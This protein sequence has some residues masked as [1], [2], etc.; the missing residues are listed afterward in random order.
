MSQK[1]THY[2]LAKYQGTPAGVA[3]LRLTKGIG[4]LQGSAVIPKFRK[5]GI[6]QALVGHRLKLLSQ[7]KI[8]YATAECL[9]DSSAPLCKDLGFETVCR[10][11]IYRCT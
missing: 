1:R 11:Q 3:A 4:H 5:M 10:F 7:L 2:F 9:K 8:P 6:Y